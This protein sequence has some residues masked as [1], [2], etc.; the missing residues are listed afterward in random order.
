MWLSHSSTITPSPPG[1]GTEHLHG[2]D[3]DPPPGQSLGHLGDA[4]GGV[5]IVDDQGI[6]SPPK[7]A[8][9]PS[10]EVTRMRPPPTEAAVRFQGAGARPARSGLPR[11]GWAERSSTGWME[12]CSPAFWARAK[13]SGRRGSSGFMPSSPATMARSVAVAPAGGGKAAVQADVG[14]QGRFAQKLAGG[15]ADARPPPRYGWK[16][17]RS[18]PAPIRQTGA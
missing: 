12:K 1:G 5:L 9:T 10:M 17:G 13:L 6:A 2:G 14:L 16:K 4:A 15:A 8:L 11:V 3:I 7:S 18:S